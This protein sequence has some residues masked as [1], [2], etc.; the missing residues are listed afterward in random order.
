MPTYNWECGV[1]GKGHEEYMPIYEYNRN[2]PKPLCCDEVMGRTFDYAPT[3]A[4]N[5]SLFGDRQFDGLR[6]TDGT[7]ISSR[8]K[9]NRYLRKTGLAMMDDFKGSW[10]RAAKDRNL[11]LKGEHPEQKRDRINHLKDAY[12]HSRNKSRYFR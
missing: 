7:D 8:D 11:R 5:N 4:R 1:C 2:P 6:A 12:E 9:H 10:D 3:D